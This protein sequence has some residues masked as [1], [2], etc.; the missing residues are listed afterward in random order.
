MVLSS[1]R[2][3]AA[4]TLEIMGGKYLL[5]SLFC[6][7]TKIYLKGDYIL[8]EMKFCCHTEFQNSFR[9]SEF[10]NFS[11]KKKLDRNI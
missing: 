3:N 6:I 2:P 8:K 4:R 10:E 5:R 9:F 7:S 11:T 1:T